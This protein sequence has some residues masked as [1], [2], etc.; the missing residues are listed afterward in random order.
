[1]ADT[2]NT[3]PGE[4]AAS[5]SVSGAEALPLLCEFCGYCIEGVP[6]TGNCPECGRA[7]YDSL[8]ERRTG[9]PWQRRANN[10][11]ARN[12]WRWAVRRPE[13]LF[14]RIRID[15][16]TSWSLRHRSARHAASW[17]CLPLLGQGMAALALGEVG[18]MMAGLLLAGVLW[19]MAYLAFVALI[20]LEEAGVRFFGRR[21]GWRVTPSVAVSV[22]AHASPA[23]LVGSRLWF[24]AWALVL[25]FIAGAPPMPGAEVQ[26]VLLLPLLGPLTGLIWFEVLVYI[27]IRRCRFANTARSPSQGLA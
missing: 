19:P 4:A 2:T 23:W 21:R 7:I 15:R 11:G 1:M 3:Q 26:W 12:T 27:G 8:P 10:R 5:T 17:F 20:K 13:R 18:W 24:V 6:E 25:L 14:G 16:D 9:S 22:C